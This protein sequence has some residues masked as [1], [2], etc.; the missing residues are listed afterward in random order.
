M[1]MIIAFTT[2]F[3]LCLGMSTA[4]PFTAGSN[5]FCV[6]TTSDNKTVDLNPIAAAV[7]DGTLVAA[8]SGVV[9]VSVQFG[10][11]GVINSTTCNVS[12][13]SMAI[14]TQ[15]TSPQCVTGF[16]VFTG[17]ASIQSNSVVFQMWGGTDGAVATVTV[18][19]DPSGA[20]GVAKLQGVIVN[21]PIYDYTFSFSSVHACP[22]S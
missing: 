4:L 18:A 21:Q 11:C 15:G 3:V 7:Y 6:V 1:K 16:E 10:W 19:C 17:P 2:F 9:D 22:S 12:D 13:W 14:N 8:A 20:T 5:A